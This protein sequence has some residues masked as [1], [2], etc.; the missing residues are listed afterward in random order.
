[1]DLQKII[2]KLHPLERKIL[3][4]LKGVKELP[5][6]VQ[7]SGLQ[8]IEVMRALQWLENKD[9]LEIIT[10]KRKIVNLE[11]NGQFYRNEG[12]PEKKFLSSLDENFKGINVIKKKSRLSKEE[13]NACIGLLKKKLAIF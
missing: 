1:M 2:L 7:K 5:E 3:P 4:F 6:I 13:M 9:L 11:E 10:D 12:L 8:E